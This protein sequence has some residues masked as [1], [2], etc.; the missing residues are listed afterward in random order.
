MFAKNSRVQTNVVL[1][2]LATGFYPKD[3]AVTIRRNERVLTADDGLKSSGLLPNNDDTF[4]R[5]ESVEVLKSDPATYSCEV[6]HKATDVGM[7]KSWG[8]KLSWF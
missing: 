3:V 4:Q 6:S 1:T 7:S 8:K 2:C 5:R